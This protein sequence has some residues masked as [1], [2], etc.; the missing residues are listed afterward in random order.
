MTMFTISVPASSANI[1]PG[2]DSVGLA[3]K[4]YLTLEV[5]QADQ[6]T[7]E[8]HESFLPPNGHY[9]DHFIY[10]VAHQVAEKYKQELPA[11][12]VKMTSQIPLARGLGSSASAVV[13][14]IE[15]A[16]QL[17]QLDLTTDEKLAIATKIEGHPDNVAPALLG[18]FTITALANEELVYTKVDE[19]ALEIILYIPNFELSTNDSREVLPKELTRDKAACASGIGNLFIAA[20]LQEDYPLAGKMM[21]ND[22]FHEPYRAK[23]IPDYV[24]IRENA[25]KHGAYGTVISG[26]GPSMLSFVPREK[27]SSLA[28]AMYQA[29]P[30]YDVLKIQ[31]DE[32]GVQVT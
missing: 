6:W 21:E 18:G 14:G 11:S 19:L 4:R 17:C 22:L 30:N 3:I 31:M 26:A 29:H 5:T 20:L 1:G 10:Q 7:F 2:F 8:H 16:N 32:R 9:K 27:S 13:S 23:L 28:E 24:N 15:L 12:H 25:K